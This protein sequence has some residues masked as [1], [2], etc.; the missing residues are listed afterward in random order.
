[1]GLGLVSSSI[2]YCF[3]TN[4]VV[5]LKVLVL[6][7]V[8]VL[9]NLVKGET[10]QSPKAGAGLEPLGQLAQSSRA[11]LRPLGYTASSLKKEAPLCE[12]CR[13]EPIAVVPGRR[14]SASLGH[15]MSW[16]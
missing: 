5:P 15:V 13:V 14:S 11:A 4:Q 6:H 2:A 3:S 8:E 7:R 10:P 9:P 16:D 12:S 1:M